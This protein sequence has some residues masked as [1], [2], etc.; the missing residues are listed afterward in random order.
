MP[1]DPLFD[2]SPG[3]TPAPAPHVKQPVDNVET[4]AMDVM[5]IDLTT[6][7]DSQEPTCSPKLSSDELRSKCQGT[8]PCPS[9]PPAVP[10]GQPRHEESKA[11]PAPTQL[12]SQVSAWENMCSNF[13]DGL[14]TFI[15]NIMISSKPIDLIN[16]YI[17]MSLVA[18]PTLLRDACL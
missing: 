14:D 16:H 17:Y 2:S 5:A 7:A 9:E 3:T 18:F 8:V 4:Q 10:P 6:L 13:M 11:S 15:I 1:I 12:D